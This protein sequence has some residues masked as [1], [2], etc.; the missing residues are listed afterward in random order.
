MSLKFED[1]RVLQMA[2]V[3]ADDIRLSSRIA[4]EGT[5]YRIPGEANLS[6]SQSDKD[7]ILFTPEEIEF[8]ESSWTT[9]TTNYQLQITN[10][11]E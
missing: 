2:E 9:S 5:S 1:L 10:Y 11:N 6:E 3:I 8:L 7:F 4:E